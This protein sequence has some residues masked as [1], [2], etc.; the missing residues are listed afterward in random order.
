MRIRGRPAQAQNPTSSPRIARRISSSQ[1]RAK[2]YR[3]TQG[4]FETSQTGRV[5]AV[6]IG[7]FGRGAQ[8][9]QNEGYGRPFCSRAQG[10]PDE[11]APTRSV[12]GRV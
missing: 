9:S 3:L 6:S 7:T 10:G 1:A 5:A 4:T 11:S 12:K 8:S 2:A